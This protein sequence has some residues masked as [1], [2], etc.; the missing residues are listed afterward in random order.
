MTS[1]N[2][3]RGGW[4]FWERLAAMCHVCSFSPL[5]L[6]VQS[7]VLHYVQHSSHHLMAFGT[8]VDAP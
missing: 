6:G 8:P 4:F 1:T 5:F 3:V 7:L 2:S